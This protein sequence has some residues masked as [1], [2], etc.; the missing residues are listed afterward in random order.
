MK[1]LLLKDWYIAKNNIIIT[2][3]SLLVIGFGISFLMES[4]SLLVLSPAVF[5]TAVFI[6]ITADAS[7]KWDRLAVTM[8]VTRQQI[9]A[10]KYL[11]Y[12]ALAAAGIVTGLIPCVILHFIRHDV[13]GQSIMLYGLLGLAASFFAGSISLLCAYR[14]A[15]ENSQVVFMVSFVGAA[16]IIAGI[17]LLT[18]LFIPVKENILAPFAMV[19]IIS[20]IALIISCK[21][22]AT[23]YAKKDI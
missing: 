16:G 23:L 6:S 20:A 13:T 18:N 15:P 7:S 8:P 11:V 22:A 4:S 10:C 5:T 19:F 1:G 12:A 21:V 14:F 17:V 3:V 2:A 9:I